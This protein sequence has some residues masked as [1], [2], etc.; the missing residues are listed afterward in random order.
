M[1]DSSLHSKADIPNEIAKNLL[2]ESLASES[3]EQQE[4]EFIAFNETLLSSLPYPAMYVRRKDRIIL[5][6]NKIALNFGAEIGNH[7]WRLFG[8]NEFISDEDYKIALKFPERVPSELNMKCIF[9]KGDECILESPTQNNPELKA[10]GRIWDTYWIKVSEDIFL[11]YLIDITERRKL[12]ES[13]KESELFLKQTQQIAMLGTYTFDIKSGFW[14][15]SEIMDSIF[16]IDNTFKKTL[17][18]WLLI[19]HPSMRET[20][21]DYFKT[22]VI[23]R[24]KG[25]DKEYK[26]RRPNDGTEHWV[27]GIGDLEFDS[28]GNPIKMIGVIR[29]ITEIKEEQSRV[30]RNLKFTEVLLKSIPIPIFFL[31]ANGLY[32]GCNEAFTD[33]QGVKSDEIKGKSAMDIWPGEESKKYF[34]SDLELIS[35]QEYQKIETK[36]ADKNN[37][38]RDVILAKNVF[39][40][41]NGQIAGLVGTYIDITDHMITEEAFRESEQ[42]LQTVLDH[43]P[44]VVFWKD[45][46]STYMGCNQSFAEGA[47]LNSPSEIIGKTDFDLP[48][49]NTEAEKYRIDDQEVIDNGDARLHIIE[50]QHQ[51]DNKV[52]WFDTSKIPFRGSNG[53]VVGVIGISSDITE[54]KTTEEEKNLLLACVENTDDRVVV[55]DLNLRV[56]AA[57]K[58]W[59]HSRG[60]TTLK[61]L[62]GETDAEAFRLPADSEPIKTY[63]EDERKAQLLK[64]GEFITKEQ[65]IKLFSGE[66]TIALVKRYPIFDEDGEL[67][68]TGTIA[69]DITERKKIENSLRKSE[70]RYKL[71]SENITDGVFTCRNG[72]LEFVN[73]SMIQILDYKASELEGLNLLDLII[74]ERRNDFEIFISVESESDQI[75]SIEIEC[76]KK[77]G[78]TIFLEIF[79]NYVANEGLIYGVLHDITQK[80]QIQERNIV[81]AIIQTEEKERANFSKELHDGLGPLLSTIKLYL[82]W[83]IRP[84]SKKSHKEIILKAEDILEEALITVK[85]ISNKLSPHLLTNYGLTSAVQSFAQKLKETNTVKIE[86]ESNL[87]R[88]IEMEVEVALYRAIIECVNNTIKY[89][90]ARQINIKITDNGHQI[91]LQYRDNGKGFDIVKTMM[92]KKGLGLFNLQ[93]RIKSI[94][95]EIMMFSK[96]R[97]GVNYHIT[98]SI[99]KEY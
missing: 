46:N 91:Q 4:K 16:G 94:G 37:E 33:Q 69:T 6:A 90:K 22:E 47:G 57:N 21:A 36:I 19:I 88:R 89:A 26:I 58:S 18:S 2:K 43:F 64:Q 10:F 39:Y 5:A 59:I 56:I 85:E 52:I 45:K 71:L 95:G 67:I 23:E 50:K 70:H 60:E 1:E 41:E 68:G 62:L 42:M 66:E 20:M 61:N 53:N 83:S 98:V 81:K 74:P 79:L 54:K 40:D 32:A 34:E 84:K 48:W 17:E 38:I 55:K 72:I 65:S 24:K 15:S 44:G 96:P 77:D 12:E 76:L 99:K 9:C 49:K 30:I 13:L 25:F 51:T 86:V 28:N 3:L 75:N 97:E 27:H 80:R 35:K 7:C 8:K 92:E 14:T 11:H 93:N 82:Q 29:D 78:S 31:D 87:D 73:K 63:M